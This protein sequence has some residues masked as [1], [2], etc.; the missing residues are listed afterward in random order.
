MLGINMARWFI[1]GIAALFLATGAAHA[2]TLPSKMLGN[3]CQVTTQE[4]RQTY[5][6]GACNGINLRRDG[7]ETGEDYGCDFKRIKRL[8]NGSYFIR[9]ECGGEGYIANEDMV[10]QIVD[11]KL[12][13]IITTIRFCVSV[14]DPPPNVIQD[15]EYDP[16]AWLALRQ[17][18]G[19]QFKITS[20][21]KH[22][23]D[24]YADIIKEDWTHITNAFRLSME[25]DNPPKIVQ[26]WVHSKYVK[27]VPCE[28]EPEETPRQPQSSIPG[29]SPTIPT[30]PVL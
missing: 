20:K 13:I 6:R 30:V 18:P 8:P 28:R 15:P 7:Y 25:G 29:F 19:T 1:A 26:G 16:N 17:G 5:A 21:L 27:K 3:W 2:D 11:H 22:G 14:I 12:E 4:H 9:A 24:L 23:D 10:F